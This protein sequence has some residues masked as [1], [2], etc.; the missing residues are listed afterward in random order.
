MGS[1]KDR[2]QRA[3]QVDDAGQ[4]EWLRWGFHERAL[5]TCQRYCELIFC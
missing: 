1:F 2:Q 5:E 3:G 4:Y